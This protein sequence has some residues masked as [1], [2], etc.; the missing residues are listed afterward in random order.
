MRKN[1]KAV[2]F[3][4][5]ALTAC[6]LGGCTRATPTTIP[7]P[8]ARC[9]K[10]QKN[11]RANWQAI[12]KSTHELEG[13]SSSLDQLEQEKAQGKSEKLIKKRFAA[14]HEQYEKTISDSIATENRVKALVN[15]DLQEIAT[16]KAFFLALKSD[17]SS[18]KL[19]RNARIGLSDAEI[20]EALKDLDQSKHMAEQLNKSL[21]E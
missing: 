18:E 17:R 16:L 19:R 4:F 13:L 21:S 8:I 6:T 14:L 20:D 5:I 3:L 7:D 9:E 12:E 2:Q 15:A 10:L 11:L 1:K